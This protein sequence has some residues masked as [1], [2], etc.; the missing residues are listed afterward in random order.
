MDQQQISTTDQIA[1]AKEYFRKVDS[2]DPNLLDMF[3]DDTEIFFP[4]FGI[5][6]GKAEIVPFLV[7]LGSAVTSFDHPEARMTFTSS[8]NRVVVEGAESGM[9]ASGVPFPGDARSSGLF[10][11]VF[12]FRGRLISRLHIY[13]DPDLA[14]QQPALFTWN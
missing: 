6:R 8:D 10:C 14:G 3:T 12:E 13:A 9:L 2:G 7:G 4:K 5:A 11:N 1:L